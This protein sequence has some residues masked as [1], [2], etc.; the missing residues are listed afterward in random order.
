MKNLKWKKSSNP[1]IKLSISNKG[2]F[3]REEERQILQD[4]LDS[5]TRIQ[6][7]PSKRPLNSPSTTQR[8]QPP[9]SSERPCRYVVINGRSGCGKSFLVESFPWPKNSFFVTG[10]FTKKNPTPTTETEADSTSKNGYRDSVYAAS[11]RVSSHG[12]ISSIEEELPFGAIQ[13]AFQ[14]LSVQWAKLSRNAC[15]DFCKSELIQSKSVVQ[16][17]LPDLAQLGGLATLEELNQ[18]FTSIASSIGDFWKEDSLTPSATG[19]RGLPKSVDSPAT[20]TS[21]NVPLRRFQAASSS[22]FPDDATPPKAISYRGSEATSGSRL[23]SITMTTKSRHDFRRLRNVLYKLLKRVASKDRPVILF[24]DDIQWADTDSLELIEFLVQ[25]KDIEGVLLVTAYRS[26]EVHTS[27]ESDLFHTQR[28][29]EL[30]HRSQGASFARPGEHNVVR[31]L[32]RLE[33]SL[34]IKANIVPLLVPKMRV[35]HL[36]GF[37]LEELNTLFAQLTQKE[38]EDTLDLIKVVHSKTNGNPFFVDQFFK[39]LQ[40]EGYLTFSFMKSSWEWEDVNRVEAAVS[41]VSTE[42]ADIVA[43]SI[44]SMDSDTQQLLMVCSCIGAQIPIQIL[45]EYFKNP[46]HDSG[47]FSVD[48]IEPMEDTKLAAQEPFELNVIL[49]DLVSNHVMKRP[50][51]RA[52][53]YLWSHEKIQQAAFSLLQERQQHRIRVKLGSVILN[54]SSWEISSRYEGLLY[55]ATNQFNQVPPLVLHDVI[56]TEGTQLK[57]VDIALLNLQAARL[58]ISKAA[59]FPAINFLR[60]GIKI[61]RPGT[62]FSLLKLEKGRSVDPWEGCYEMYLELHNNLFET[63]YLLGNHEA[64]RE[65]LDTVLTNA[66]L[67]EEKLRAQACLL[68]IL[69][70]GSDRNYKAALKECRKILKEFGVLIPSKTSRMLIKREKRKLNKA[71]PNR[72]IESIVHMPP[73]TDPKARGISM[74]LAMLANYASLE[75]KMHMCHLA[76]LKSFLLACEYGT[77]SYIAVAMANF[78]LSLRTEGKRQE[79]NRMAALTLDCLGAFS[80]EPGY[81]HAKTLTIVHSSLIPMKKPLHDSLDPYLESFQIGIHTGDVEYALISVMCYGLHYL[82]VGLP[83][84]PFAQDCRS[85]GKDCKLFGLAPAVACMFS[86]MEQTVECLQGRGTGHCCY[87][88][89]HVVDQAELLAS[90]DGKGRDMTL[91]DISMYRLMLSCIF[92]DMETGTEMLD[93]LANFKMDNPSIARMHTRSAF[94]GLMAYSIYHKT[95]QQKYKRMARK[96]YRYFK[97]EVKHGSLNAYPV[98]RLLQA[99]A[100]PSKEAFDRAIRVCSRSGLMNFEAIANETAAMYLIE[101]HNDFEWGRYYLERAMALFAEWGCTLKVKRLQE[102]YD[103]NGDSNLRMGGHGVKGTRKYSSLFFSF[104]NMERVD[105][106]ESELSPSL[107]ASTKKFS[108]KRTNST[109]S[110]LAPPPLIEEGDS[111]GEEEA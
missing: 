12:S 72:E 19:S 23:S 49:K 107:F 98:F 56:T 105:F 55:I 90:M 68:E 21:I 8:K 64:A 104:R 59:Y 35:M 75:G 92:R 51:D 88:K 73:M 48:G 61:L 71:L 102:E 62:N 50:S 42:V 1:T 100:Q 24:L 77:N 53:V 66:R 33:R 30:T 67:P 27:Q 95:K 93:V 28:I 110:V 89:G 52:T 96:S 29:S 47:D 13:Q 80:E 9:Q 74:I 83:L 86:M 78:G 69:S 79:C 20:P 58:S 82:F 10:R 7:T 26:E 5:V 3:G 16:N 84:S 103:F 65:I 111:N 109:V 60:T 37:T 40:R 91:R 34:E 4:A 38:P 70:S 81:N 14:D 99:A 25:E 85:W 97:N 108:S 63:E 43:S 18:N 101:K 17:F 6:P 2:H 41:I 15:K 31:H 46:L 45:H 11:A 87:L 36:N 106:D 44:T 94:T 57:V 39:L 76:V 22:R 54:M 32:H